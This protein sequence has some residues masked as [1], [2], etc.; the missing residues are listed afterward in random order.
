MPEFDLRGIMFAKYNNTNGVVSYSDATPAG[1]AMAVNL[2]L[3]Y[4]EGRLYAESSLAEY[5]RKATG[6]TIS[7]GVK[8]IPA[9]AQKLLYGSKDKQRTITVG[10]QTKTI[11]GLQKSTSDTYTAVG[12]AFYAPDMVD[13]V[14]KYTC[15]FIARSMFGAPSMAFQTAGE[16]ITFNTPTTTGEFMPDHTA[17][18]VVT[19]VATVDTV[20][21]AIA[22]R[23]AVLN[24]DPTAA[25]Q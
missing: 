16:S 12:T 8:Y 11:T 3:R 19:E 14:E 24:Y 22:W 10:T 6:G 21:E 7:I 15:V 17:D 23:N 18:K 1:D 13:G 9:A 5:I 4:A 20:E 25:E 2:E